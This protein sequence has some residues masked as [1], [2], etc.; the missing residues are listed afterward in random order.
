MES[1]R[2]N[3]YVQNFIGRELIVLGCRSVFE[4]CVFLP[5]V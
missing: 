4:L 5:H 1:L 3:N 2:K